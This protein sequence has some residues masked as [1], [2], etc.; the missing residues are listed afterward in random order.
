MKGSNRMDGYGRLRATALSVII[1][2]TPAAFWSDLRSGARIIYADIFAEVDNDRNVLPQQKLDKL[3]QDRHF[4][5]EKLLID[6]ATKHGLHSSTTV[7][8]E[9][10]RC[11]AYVARGDVAMTQ[12][13][14]QDIGRMPHPAKFRE[15]YAAAM[16][17]PRLDLGD[18]PTEVMLGRQ[19]YGLIAHNPVGRRFD[20]DEQRLGMIQFCLPARDCKAWTV[21]FAVAEILAGYDV[22]KKPVVEPSRSPTWKERKDEEGGSGEGETE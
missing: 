22:E 21:E 7:I 10:N 18:E 1:R 20:A 8:I 2:D 5:M 15:R 3:L 14:V 19:F 12:S 11:H 9:N 16:D 4:R 6:L 17:L 13:Y